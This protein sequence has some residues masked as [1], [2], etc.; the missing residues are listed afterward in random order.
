MIKSLIIDGL[1]GSVT[2]LEFNFN[3]D[4]NLFTGLNGCGKTTILKILWF[5]NSGHFIHLLNEV[6]FQSLMLMTDKYKVEIIRKDLYA[7]I[8]WNT[9]NG[10][11]KDIIPFMDGVRRP[12][13]DRKS[14]V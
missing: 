1:N 8:I 4:L 14:V 11:K 10:D 2:P 7:D 5:V 13:S 9:G 6:M 12:A 3:G